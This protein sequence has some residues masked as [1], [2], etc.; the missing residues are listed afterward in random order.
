LPGKEPRKAAFPLERITYGGD[1]A[2]AAHW[3]R[4]PRAERGAF[5]MAD[6]K[7]LYHNRLLLDRFLREFGISPHLPKNREKVRRLLNYGERAA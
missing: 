3:A 5:S 6:V 2:K 1:L 7:T 4:V